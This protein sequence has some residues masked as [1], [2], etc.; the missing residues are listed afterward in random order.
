VKKQDEIDALLS[1]Y[2]EH[3]PKTVYL[4]RNKGRYEEIVKAMDDI[5]KFIETIESDATFEISKDELIGTSLAL[6]VTCTL[7]SMTE[8]DQFCDAIKKADSID[9]TPKTDGNL[10]VIFGFNDAYVPAPPKKQS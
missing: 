10:S 3:M 4:M 7:L 8:V 6:E 9:I 5:K 1:F 2:E